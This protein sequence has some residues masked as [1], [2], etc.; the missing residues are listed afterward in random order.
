MKLKDEKVKTP[1]IPPHNNPNEYTGEV[2]VN[3]IL[4]T[5]NTNKK[6]LFIEHYVC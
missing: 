5:N 1:H 2:T 6:K 4:N 3:H